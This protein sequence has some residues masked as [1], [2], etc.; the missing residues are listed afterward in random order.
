[1]AFVTALISLAADG[2]SLNLEGRG[3]FVA[4]GSA[5]NR[6]ILKA[7]CEADNANV[8]WMTPLAVEAGIADDSDITLTAELSNVLSTCVNTP[9]RVPCA[10]HHPS[11]PKLFYF[12]LSGAGGSK[13]LGPVA[14]YPAVVEVLAASGGALQLA[15]AVRANV[16]LPPY[17]DLA[18]ITGYNGDGLPVTVHVAVTHYV[19]SGP[20][21][22]VLPFGG[23]A[24]GDNITITGLPMPPSL[25]PPLSPPTP[26]TPKPPMPSPPPPLSIPCT[27]QTATVAQHQY[28]TCRESVQG[29]STTTTAAE[30]LQ[31]AVDNPGKCK[32]RPATAYW[33]SDNKHCSCVV[34]E[35]YDGLG[36][37]DS[38]NCAG[39]SSQNAFIYSCP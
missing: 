11:V 31:V 22:L 25:P 2:G 19:P 34:N 12:T 13:V 15:V 4:F 32:Y 6:A 26:P 21:A 24:G 7:T 39:G 38:T 30:C 35:D 33:R 18:Y 14:A 28:I 37:N 36:P 16:T 29:K 3:A 8:A 27:M 1:M 20:E 17:K 9:I 10:S 5:D 23:V